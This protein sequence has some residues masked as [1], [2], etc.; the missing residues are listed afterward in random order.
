MKRALTITAIALVAVVMTVGAII[1]AIA[2]TN[3][4][5]FVVSI[6]PAGKHGVIER[7]DDGSNTKYQFNIPRDLQN[8]AESPQVGN[9]A[10]FDI[11]PDKS[12]HATNVITVCPPA[13]GGGGGGA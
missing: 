6:N 3:A 13:C 11:I 2:I 8:P 1:P 5:G 9:F 10:I 12:R 7:T 4:N